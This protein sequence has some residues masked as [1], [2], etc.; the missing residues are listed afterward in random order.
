MEK[1]PHRKDI[2]RPVREKQE[3]AQ[4]LAAKLRRRAGLLRKFAEKYRNN[5]AERLYGWKRDK[6]K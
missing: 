1:D 4:K 2:E 3:M 5:S 6:E